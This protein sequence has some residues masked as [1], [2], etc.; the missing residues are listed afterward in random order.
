MSE[1]SSEQ[2]YGRWV[3]IQFDCLPLRSVGRLDVPLDASPVYEQFVLRV[4]KAMQTHG[5]HNSYYLHRGSCRFH[6]TNDSEM[7]EIAFRFEGTVLTGE[8]DRKTRSMDLTVELDRETCSWLSE[9]I[10]QFFFGECS[11]CGDGRVWSLHRGGRPLENRGT[12]RKAR[13]AK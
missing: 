4:K 2:R 3:E 7:G 12:H 10:V 11:A 9:P 13:R 1:Q 8:K 5:S 6:L